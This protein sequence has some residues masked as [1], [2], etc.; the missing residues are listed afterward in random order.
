MIRVEFSYMND[1]FVEIAGSFRLNCMGEKNE[2][3]DVDPDINTTR[4]ATNITK[5]P[6]SEVEVP[7]SQATQSVVEP[8]MPP[9]RRR[10]SSSVKQ[11]VAGDG[12]T[13]E[14]RWAIFQ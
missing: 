2:E 8:P 13:E 14:P 1:L 10:S 3:V 12:D 9:Q 4:L 11:A 5:S 7:P 6:S